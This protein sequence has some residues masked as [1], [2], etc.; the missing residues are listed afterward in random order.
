MKKSNDT[1][2][3]IPTIDT[4]R[5]EEEEPLLLDRPL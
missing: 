3:N 1:N 4:N 2:D 5:A